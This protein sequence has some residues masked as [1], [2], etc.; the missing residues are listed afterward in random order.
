MTSN[1]GSNYLLEA[2]ETDGQITQQV[3]DHVFSE[4]RLHFRPEFL[5]RIDDIILFQPLS[6]KTI[7]SI[8]EKL[9]EELQTRLDDQHIRLHMTDDAKRFIA[10]ESYDPIYGARPLKRF[11]QQHVETMLARAIIRGDVKPHETITIHVDND[12]FVLKK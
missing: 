4:L 10:K 8:V 6:E 9:F 3:R 2:I 11:I 5:N 7:T 1:I 12:Q